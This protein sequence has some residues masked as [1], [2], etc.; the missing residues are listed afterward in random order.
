MA[1]RPEK[2]PHGVYTGGLWLRTSYHPEMQKAA[3]GA[4]RD[5][6]MR[7]DGGRSWR[8]SGLSIDMS[9]DWRS[10]LVIADY[11]VGYDD[12]RA[13]VVI[14]KSGGSATIGF[15]D[16][17]TGTLPSSAA[18]MPKRGAGGAAFG[19]L[20]PGMIIAVK[21]V[22][23]DSYALRS[24]PEI[25]G[26][27]VA[28]EVATGASLRCRAVGTHADP[29]ST[30]PRRRCASRARPSSRSSIRPRSTTA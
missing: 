1:R 5:G 3:E 6:L 22:S 15:T 9:K 2:G 14:E 29:R 26:A 4:L 25:G 18:S 20:R 10:Q 19:Y 11:G 21:R 24:V 8:D 30:A 17:T 23:G 27:F 28:Q 7:Y 13:A 16:G 12:W